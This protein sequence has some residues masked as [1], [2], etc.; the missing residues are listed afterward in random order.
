VCP[1]NGPAIGSS[2]SDSRSNDLVAVIA[3]RLPNFVAIRPNATENRPK[4]PE[5]L[6]DVGLK[7]GILIMVDANKSVLIGC[8]RFDISGLDENDPYFASIGDDF[9]PEFKRLCNDLICDDYVCADVG[10]NLGIKT[11]LLAQRVPNGRVIAI[12][13]APAV[14]KLLEKNISLSD[15]KNITI[16]K[17]AIGDADGTTGFID[18]S[19]YGHI[20]TNGR[21]EVPVQRLSTLVSD[22]SLNRLDFVKIDVEGYEFPILKNSMELL[23]KF[24]SVILLEFNSWCQIAWSDINPKEFSEW[25]LTKFSHVYAVLRNAT[26]GS[27]L[28]RFRQGEAL[29]LL[30]Y[31]MVEDRLVTDLLVTNFEERLSSLRSGL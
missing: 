17:T 27:S 4:R 31:N 16:V 12:E 25:V 28:R 13:A 11:L 2:A 18:A 6:A 19:A 3:S 29:D 21:V 30:H 24:K 5:N 22:L 10:A 26:D 7:R 9:E 8:Q 15:M 1:E 14:A 20:S 23:N